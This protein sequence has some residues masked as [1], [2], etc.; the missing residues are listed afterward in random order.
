M[1][2]Y[3]SDQWQYTNLDSGTKAE[4]EQTSGKGQYI[5]GDN[6]GALFSV[7]TPPQ[8]IKK[9]GVLMGRRKRMKS[10]KIMR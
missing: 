10:T 1:D 2:R 5:R 8:E 6:G 7:P 9:C 4:V 3:Y